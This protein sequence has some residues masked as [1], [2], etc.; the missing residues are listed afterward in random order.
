[1]AS[2]DRGAGA[3]PYTRF[4]QW[5]NGR[6]GITVTF[7]RRR[8]P[9]E[10]FAAFGCTGP[11][12]G[13]LSLDEAAPRPQPDPS[14]PA[15]LTARQAELLRRQGTD[16]SIEPRILD[17]ESQLRHSVRVG[18][19]P[20]W[21]FAVEWF[22]TRGSAPELLEALSAGD[23]EAVCLCITQKASVV[24]YAHDGILVSGFDIDVAHIRYG[25]D[26]HHFDA[27]MAEAGFTS[28][29]STP[30]AAAA[31]LLHLRFG[32]SLDAEELEAPLPAALLPV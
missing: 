9:T 32:I 29:R 23:R 3:D 2:E 10:V 25:A 16:P 24:L 11:D 1:V 31:R 6:L 22:T 30:A 13:S 4:A 28:P 17:A 18:T 15:A 21:A 19:S 27:A 7:A 12:E 14:R 26:P 5:V 8:T 20:E